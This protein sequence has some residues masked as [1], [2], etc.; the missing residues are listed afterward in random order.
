MQKR[1]VLLLVS[2]CGCGGSGADSPSP[3]SIYSS[4][5]VD[6]LIQGLAT[7]TCA[8]EFR[9][10][11][12]AAIQAWNGGRYKDAAGC[13]PFHELDL[14]RDL[15]ADRLEVGS[16]RMRVDADK[17]A[18]CLAEW[19]ALGCSGRTP[20]PNDPSSIGGDCAEMF[21][22]RRGGAGR[23]LRAQRGVHARQRLPRHRRR[24]GP[25]RR[26][27]HLRAAPDRGPDLQ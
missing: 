5:D 27:R 1:I 22:R 6:D 25:F 21:V 17:A 7:A 19:N 8:W 20:F 11:T 9:C 3:T 26:Q 4:A 10:C 15:Y 16:G 14:K 13:A 2:L 24:A 18:A 23:R 12:D